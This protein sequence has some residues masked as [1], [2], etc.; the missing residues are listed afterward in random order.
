MHTE[1]PYSW[2]KGRRHPNRH[3]TIFREM[4][5]VSRT[6]RAARHSRMSKNPAQAGWQCGRSYITLLLWSMSMRV[7]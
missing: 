1:Y 7:R 2:R 3:L 4:C 6:S 5:N